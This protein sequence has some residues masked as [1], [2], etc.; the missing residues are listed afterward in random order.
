VFPGCPATQVQGEQHEDPGEDQE[1][2]E[3]VLMDT[4]NQ[5]GTHE[6]M[7]ADMGRGELV[8]THTITALW[9]WDTLII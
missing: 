9:N 8:S 7:G 2:N 6:D 5:H 3:A 1:Q 4:C